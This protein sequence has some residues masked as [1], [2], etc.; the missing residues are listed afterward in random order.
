MAPSWTAMT[1]PFIVSTNAALEYVDSAGAQHVLSWV[2]AQCA[3]DTVLHLSLSFSLSLSLFLSLARSL[4][5]SLSPSFT[6]ALTC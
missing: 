2:Y 5:L 3:V 4:S 6:G 1:F